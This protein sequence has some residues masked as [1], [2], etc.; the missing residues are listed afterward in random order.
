MA[1]KFASRDGDDVLIR[2][3]FERIEEILADAGIGAASR[4]PISIDDKDRF[5][6]ELIDAVNRVPAVENML[7]TE[8]EVMIEAGSRTVTEHGVNKHRAA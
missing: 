6:S 2:V 7:T 3:P 1:D 4:H 5:L 8:V